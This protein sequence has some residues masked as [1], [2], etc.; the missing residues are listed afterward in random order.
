MNDFAADDTA[1]KSALRAQLGSNRRTRS[2]SVKGRS[3]S[4]RGAM[5]KPG[6]GRLSHRGETVQLNVNVEPQWKDWLARAK[7]DHNMAIFEIVERGLALV[8]AELERG[9]P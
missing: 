4:E 5:A 2:A 7:H 1:I 3:K 6:D 9:K 8:R